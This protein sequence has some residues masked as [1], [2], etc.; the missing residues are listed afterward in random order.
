VNHRN[1][2]QHADRL[3][4]ETHPLDR[5]HPRLADQDPL[6]AGVERVLER[7]DDRPLRGRLSL[8]L[9]RQGESGFHRLRQRG[10]DYRDRRAVAGH[11]RPLIGLC[12]VNMLTDQST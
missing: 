11:R 9:H 7:S 12:L 4:D 8:T 2:R 1:R 10:R 3:Q 6:A 5:I